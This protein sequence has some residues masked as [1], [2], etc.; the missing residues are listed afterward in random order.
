MQLK[1]MAA[2]A[3]ATVSIISMLGACSSAAKGVTDT[4]KDKGLDV[5]G[6]NIK[7]DPNHLVNNGKPI[8]LEYWTWSDSG[9]DPV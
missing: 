8:T 5:I 9:V 4:K 7:Y 1:K 2:G 6:T 3:I